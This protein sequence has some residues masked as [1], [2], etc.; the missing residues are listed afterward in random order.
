M[1]ECLQCG[2]SLNCTA[3]SSLDQDVYE[4]EELNDEPWKIQ[5]LWQPVLKSSF[6]SL[7]WE[8]QMGGMSVIK[9]ARHV[10]KKDDKKR[11][12]QLATNNEAIW[13][14]RVQP[15]NHGLLKGYIFASYILLFNPEKRR[16]R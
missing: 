4:N 14:L 16:G 6:F 8:G 11:Q 13:R 2:P 15:R 7:N 10:Q 5:D 1:A 3:L 9:S 12:R